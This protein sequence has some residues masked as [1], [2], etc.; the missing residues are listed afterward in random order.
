MLLENNKLSKLLLF[1]CLEN[2]KIEKIPH[3]HKQ[4]SGKLFFRFYGVYKI[5]NLSGIIL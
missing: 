1:L 4:F 3:F 5:C 2:A